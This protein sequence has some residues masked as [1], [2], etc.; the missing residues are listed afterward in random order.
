MILNVMVKPGSKNAHVE[1]KNGVL[2]VYTKSRAEAGKA[3]REMI[4]LLAKY[5]GVSSRDISIRT[6][7]AS[8][9]KL[10]EIKN[11]DRQR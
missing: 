10:V 7:H 3:N 6:G 8:R 5:L 4:K 1:E 9:K 11:A 2:I